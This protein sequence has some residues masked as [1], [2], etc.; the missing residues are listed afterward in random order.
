[1]LSLKPFGTFQGSSDSSNLYD[2]YAHR[3]QARL[4]S[5]RNGIYI[6][7]YIFIYLYIYIYIFI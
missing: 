5:V 2:N 6:Y 1:M 7:I 3:T 4:V